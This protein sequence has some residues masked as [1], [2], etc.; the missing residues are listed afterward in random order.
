MDTIIHFLTTPNETLCNFLII[1]LMFIDTLVNMLLFT[2]ILN[3][4]VDKKQKLKYILA[5]FI[6]GSIIKI[7]IPNKINY[8]ICLLIIIFFVRKILK[9]SI[10]KC[11]IS[12]GIIT[13]ASGISEAIVIGTLRLFSSIDLTI[14]INIPIYRIFVN[15]GIYFIIYAFYKF[16]LFFKININVIDNMPK[17]AQRMLILNAILGILIIIPYTLFINFYKNIL[18]NIFL[19]S[20]LISMILFFIISLY[21]TFKSTELAA[22]KEELKNAELYNKTL[23]N[24]YDNIR[25]FKHDFNNMVQVIGGFI[26]SQDLVGLK[27]YYSSLVGDCQANNNL[28]AL[29]PESINNPAIFGL[30]ASKYLFADDNCI[31]MNFEIFMDLSKLNVDIYKLSKIL[32][33]LIDNALE[34]SLEANEK[35]VNIL[36][37]QDIN[38]K[39]QIIKIENTFDKNSK[40]NVDKIYEKDF[41]TKNRNSGIGLWEVNKIVNKTS[42]LKLNTFVDDKYFC[43]E[44]LIMPN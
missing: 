36:M 16:I 37:R 35:V 25:T 38:T 9:T 18:P 41:S 28:S 24:L 15:L 5:V 27:R 2:T 1:P 14:A 12:C 40:I 42:N 17:K 10:L 6:I 43:Q 22:T 29:N 44:L 11:I 32:G 8:F 23:N 4:K 34:A 20:F 30:L 26:L 19:I 31:K 13:I 21:T 33:I 3:I 39:V 7:L